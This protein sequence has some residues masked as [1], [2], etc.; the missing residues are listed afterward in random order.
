VALEAVRQ[1]LQGHDP[2]G[3]G[4]VGLAV[5]GLVGQ[6]L[7]VGRHRRQPPG[8]PAGARVEG[9][10]EWVF[11]SMAGTYQAPPEHQHPRRIWLF[12]IE[13]VVGA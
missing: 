5:Q 7:E 9:L 1:A 8:V 12:V 13:G 3:P 2:V 6:L 11:E 10:V 4:G